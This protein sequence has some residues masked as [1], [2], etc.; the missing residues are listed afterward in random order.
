MCPNR[1]ETL[2]QKIIILIGG[3][4][5][6]GHL[7]FWQTA[8]AL[9]SIQKTEGGAGWKCRRGEICELENP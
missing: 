2:G 7:F 3:W 6:G 5:R 9:P 4:G 8:K 1:S